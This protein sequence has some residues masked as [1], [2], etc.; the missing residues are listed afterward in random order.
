[1]KTKLYFLIALIVLINFNKTF[2]QSNFAPLGATWHH[3]G[4]E[5]IYKSIAL[6]DTIVLGKNCRQVKQRIFIS[7]PGPVYAMDLESTRD[8]YIYSNPDTVF[9]F[10]DRINRFS[11]LFVFNV[12]VGDTVR[13]PLFNAPSLCTKI[14]NDTTRL[15]EFIVD[16]VKNVNYDGEILKTVYSKCII[17]KDLYKFQSQ[18]WFYWGDSLN[19]YAEKIGSL[20]TGL[21]PYC[22]GTCPTLATMGCA[23]PRN[24]RCYEDDSLK[25]HL[26][27]TCL[28][29]SW[30]PAS[31]NEKTT[32]TRKLII[33]P[34][35]ANDKI[36]L[37][38]EAI[39]YQTKVIIVDVMGK[40]VIEKDI[41]KSSTPSLD[42]AE[43]KSGVYFIKLLKE[44]DITI[45]SGSFVKL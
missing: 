44:G 19:V 16:S 4:Y 34:N 36:N 45:G 27:D 22:V 26:V 30:V 42:V 43:L 15:F 28:N 31:I 39:N 41:L 33:F 14:S 24:L 5:G 40:K 17:P 23:F 20:K 1:M 11:P 12:K 10:N 35:P 18:G 37:G 9:C 3:S 13:L 29:P 6:K 7:W 38:F 2:A 32:S 21:L 8:L 25:I